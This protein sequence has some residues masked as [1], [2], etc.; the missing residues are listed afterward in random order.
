MHKQLGID[1]LTLSVMVLS[2][3]PAQAQT[4][5][6]QV[7][8][9][10]EHDVSLPLAQMPPLQPKGGPRT[11]PLLLTHPG[12]PATIQADPVVQTSIGSLAA[13]TPGLGFAG[14]GNGDYSFT[15]NAAP[16]DTNGAVGATQFVQWVNE[17]FAVFDK[18]T[19]AKLYGPVAANTL[20]S[21]FGGGCQNNNDGD[22]IVQYDKAAGRW[23]FTQF[24]VSTTPYLQCVAVSKT[25][26]ATGAYN[27]YAFQ[28]GNFPDYPKLGVWPDAYYMTFNMFQG[29][30]F[31][32][33]QVCA[34]DRASMLA[35]TQATQQCFQ[36]SSSFGSVLPSDVDGSIAPPTG[37]PNFMLNFGTNSLNLWKF[38]VDWT[39]QANTTLTG[40]INIPVAAFSEACNGGSCIPQ[41]GTNQKLDSLGDRLMYRLAYR[42]FGDHEALVANHSVGSPSEVRWYELRNP[43]G[44]PIVYQQGTFAPDSSYR[45]MGSIAM[46]RSGNI[47]LGYSVS[48]S[49]INPGIR[50]TGR[51]ST[52]LL[53]TMQTESTI[54][55]GTGSQLSNLNRW[56]DYSSMSVD[57]VDD[58]TFW[59]TNEYLKSSGTFNWSTWIASFK[60]PNCGSTSPVHDVTVRSVMA[61]SPVVVNTAQTVSATVTNLGTQAESFTVSLSDSLSSSITSTPQTVTN[62]AAGA[63]QSVTFGWTPSVTGTHSLTATASTVTGETNTGNNILQTTSIVNAASAGPPTITSI[64]PTTMKSGTSTTSFMITGT[65][66]VGGATVTF[67]NGSGPAPTASAATVNSSGTIITA[68]VTVPAGGAPRNRI[69]DVKVTN[70]NG[71]SAVISQAFTVTP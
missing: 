51:V 52:D 35:G 60:F 14:L 56:G 49:S 17:S 55:N 53:N 34:Y 8:A 20:W 47:A 27:R 13:T 12:Q 36:L 67:Q 5:G 57:P 54:I 69:W 4:H 22:P 11:K 66:F 19:G 7:S 33:S 18:A 61:P 58:C 42:N 62:L 23:I 21:G 6:A 29:N 40:P 32:G 50:Y 1:L 48:S 38:H 59:Y 15:P 64:S 39:T 63:S 70:P 43:G 25:S 28:Y 16:P 65:N 30:F 68:T 2:A 10:I 31:A 45:W 37:A 71:Q 26:D 9:A 44:T 24:S 46:D 41:A 3:L